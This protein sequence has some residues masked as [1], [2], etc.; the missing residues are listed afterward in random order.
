ML[1][2]EVL[3]ALSEGQLT[4]ALDVPLAEEAARI[5]TALPAGTRTR[6]A[7]ALAHHR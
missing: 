5:V 1:T 4:D 2:L 3:L 6:V 7:H